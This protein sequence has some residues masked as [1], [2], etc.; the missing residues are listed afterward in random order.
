[1]YCARLSISEPEITLNPPKM[2]STSRSELQASELQLALPL[3]VIALPRSPGK[4]Q[5]LYTDL[6]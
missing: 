3:R 6:Y 4:G 2:F 1:M 5:A